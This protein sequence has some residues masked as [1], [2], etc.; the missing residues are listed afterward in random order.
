MLYRANMGFVLSVSFPFF[1][2]SLIISSRSSSSN[3][4]SKSEESESVCFRLEYGLRCRQGVK[5]TLT[6]SLTY[7]SSWG[8]GFC[9]SFLSFPGLLDIGLLN[10]RL[11]LA[12]YTPVTGIL[13]AIG[14]GVILGIF[15]GVSFLLV[16]LAC[17]KK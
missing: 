8:G 4:M 14:I 12:C 2:S 1:P 3:R 15:L 10:N 6:H 16:V 9:A 13:I 7:P 5:S 11:T 17:H